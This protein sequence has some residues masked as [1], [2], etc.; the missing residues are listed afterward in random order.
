VTLYNSKYPAGH[1]LKAGL[2][3]S[4]NKPVCTFAQLSQDISCCC[5]DLASLVN[6]KLGSHTDAAGFSSFN[7]DSRHRQSGNDPVSRRIVSGS[8]VR[9]GVP[10]L[11]LAGPEQD[12]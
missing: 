11:G 7:R 6:S 3:A 12:L 10:P 5:K 9:L 4:G 2:Y 1:E 8:D